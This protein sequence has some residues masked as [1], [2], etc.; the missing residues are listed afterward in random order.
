MGRWR[1]GA[2]ATGA[3]LLGVGCG[4]SSGAL[5]TPATDGGANGGGGLFVLA[6]GEVAELTV[7]GGVAA[8]RLATPAGNEQF[9]VVV[10]STS[11]GPGRAPLAYSVSLDPAE[12]PAP[13]ALR[14]TCAID[15]AP[16]ATASLPPGT[17]PSGT[18]VA[19]GATR[20]INVSSAT[21]FEAIQAT[22]VAVGKYA[23][24]WADVTPAHPAVLDAAFAQEFLTDFESTIMPRERAVFG[25]ESDLD[26]DGH[27]QLVFTPVTA[28]TAIAFFTGC[29]LGE[30]F[31]CGTTNSGEYLYLT[32]PNAI[33][34]PYNTPTAIKEILAH[35]LS[36]LIHY[37]RKVLRNGLPAWHDS[38]Y[39]IEGVGGFAQ[40][41]IG[42]QA[43]NF[44]VAMAGMDGIDKFSIADTLVDDTRYDTTRDGVLRGVSY[45]FV[46]WLYDRAGGD[47]ANADGTLANKGG[48]SLLRRLL[49]APKT[50]TGELPDATRSTLADTTVDFYTTLAMSNRDEASIGGVAPKNPCF[51]FLPAPVDP[52]TGKQRGANVYTQ[53]HGQQMHG[54][55]TQKAAAADGKILPGGVEVLTLDAAAGQAEVDVTL[56]VDPK[57]AVRVRVGRVR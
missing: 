38:G 23:V 43:G 30:T 49:D 39:M 54:P 13:S 50:I 33:A 5:S 51:A 53:F 36:H 28:D 34:P 27:I 29:D 4:K 6:P 10:A 47:A 56:T 57:A 24:V 1:A 45:L 21:G 7:V 46:R 35:E 48:A 12:P 16:W 22:A 26:K 25:V 31:G 2:A 14:T 44:Y 9:V 15:S 19:V 41:V 52:V 55:K 11:L 3:L 20:T 32:P 18:T 8:E 40:D 42:F 17:P 37:G